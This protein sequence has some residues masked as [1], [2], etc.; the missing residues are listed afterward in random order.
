MNPD[1]EIWRTQQKKQALANF[2]PGQIKKVKAFWKNLD[3]HR[4]V[5]KVL[6]SSLTF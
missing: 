6:P 3:A 4:G 2:G 5:D 1:R